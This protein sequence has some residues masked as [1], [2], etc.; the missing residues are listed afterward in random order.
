MSTA[1][2]GGGLTHVWLSGLAVVVVIAA[3]ALFINRATAPDSR[4]LLDPDVGP[5]IYMEGAVLRQFGADGLLQYELT[6]ATLRF[7]EHNDTAHLEAPLLILYDSARRAWQ[8]RALEGVL[9][10]PTVSGAGADRVRL[11]NDVLLEPV[12]RREQIRLSTSMLTLYP[13]RQYAE[14]DQAVIIDGDVGRTAAA[15]LEGDLQGGL[16]KLFSSPER[17]VQTVLL[18]GQ[19]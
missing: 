16:L 6:T 7:F 18:P 17:P 2:D 11:L 13:D 14:T 1:H 15:G 10:S 9:H 12:E 4:G 19:F 3:G 8:V 5:D